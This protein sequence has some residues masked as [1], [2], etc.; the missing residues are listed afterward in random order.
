[1]ITPHAHM[2]ALIHPSRAVIHRGGRPYVPELLAMLALHG[3]LPG[4][5]GVD[6]GVL[7]AVP[8]EMPRLVADPAILLALFSLP[9]ASCRRRASA[10]APVPT[11]APSQRSSWSLN[12]ATVAGPCPMAS[13]APGR[14]LGFHLSFAAVS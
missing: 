13:T 8:G 11:S 2:Q 6:P 3:V 14:P 10:P 12:R 9:W 1:M 4:L 7:G 5:D